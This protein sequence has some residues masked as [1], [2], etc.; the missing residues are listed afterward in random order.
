MA[1]ETWTIKAADDAAKA[2]RK[3]AAAKYPTEDCS[4]CGGKGWAQWLGTHAPPGPCFKCGGHG[5]QVKGRANQKALALECAAI[6]VDRLRRC[7][8]AA[9]DAVRVAEAAVAAEPGRWHLAHS[10]KCAKETLARYEAA[11]KA[12]VKAMKE[13]A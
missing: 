9:R 6:E 13:A 4:R 3:A 8:L 12:A 10:V 11:G 2:A 7:W 1:N 5:R